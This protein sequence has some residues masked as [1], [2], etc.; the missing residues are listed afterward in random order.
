MEI[1]ILILLPKKKFTETNHVPDNLLT[2]SILGVL[3][4]FLARPVACRSSQAR[5]GNCATGATPA[6]AV[7]TPD[8]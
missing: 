8:P 3:V 2:Y 4:W 1:K 5:D 6:A 7:T